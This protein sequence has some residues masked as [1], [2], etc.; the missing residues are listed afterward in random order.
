MAPNEILKETL[1]SLRE[2]RR[3]LMS[4]DWHDAIEGKAPAERRKA[5]MAL[6]Q[7]QEALLV[8]GNAELA[9][10]RDKLKENEK[11]LLKGTKNLYKALGNL[12]R[13]KKVL[14]TITALLKVAARIAGMAA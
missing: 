3:K 10:I 11:E 12:K 13:V 2:T 7:V 6:F 9:A 8:L 5:A 14:E 1:A 4:Q